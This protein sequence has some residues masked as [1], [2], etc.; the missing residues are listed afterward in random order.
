[1]F[2][3]LLTLK[4]LVVNKYYFLDFSEQDNISLKFHIQYFIF[5]ALNNLDLKNLSIMFELC[6]S[7]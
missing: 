6:Y 2:I 1:M 5:D 7:F 3:K 4:I